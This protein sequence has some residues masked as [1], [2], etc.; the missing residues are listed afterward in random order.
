MTV[1]PFTE[2]KMPGKGAALRKWEE[3]QESFDIFS[4]KC[5]LAIPSSDIK[6]RVRG[7]ARTENLNLGIVHRKMGNTV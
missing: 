2:M 6:F 3:N 4:L 7:E 1:T 5:L